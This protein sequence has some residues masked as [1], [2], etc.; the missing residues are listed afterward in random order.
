[1]A[2][3][4]FHVSH[5]LNR[6]PMHLTVLHVLSLAIVVL[7]LST[8]PTEAADFH[9]AVDGSD[10]NP[11]TA[12]KPFATLEKARDA[13]RSWRKSNPADAA[14]TVS[15][16]GGHYEIPKPLLLTDEDSGTEQAPVRWRNDKNQKVVLSGGRT[17]R[18]FKPVTDDRVLSRLPKD[19]HPHV[20]Q[21]DLSDSN[22]SDLGDVAGAG[23]RIEL[24]F[25]GNP[26]TLARWPNEGFTTVVDVNG[27]QP[28]QV[29]GIKGDAVGRFIYQGEQ[30]TR[31]TREPDVWVFG[32]WFWDWSDGVQPV[33][34]ID[35]ATKTI[36]LAPPHHSYGFRKGQRF[37][38]F[39]ILAE[40]DQP[41]EWYLDRE[42]RML[43]FWPPTNMPDLSVTLSTTPNLLSIKNASW[44]TWQG[45]QFEACRA[46]AIEIEQG[47]GVRIAGCVVR[48]TGT[49]GITIHQGTRHGVIGCDIDQ[50]GE[51]G[52]SLVGGDRKTLTPAG[53]VAE[54]NHIHH[55]ARLIRTYRP[56]IG[57]TGVGHRLS[58]NLIHDA[59]HT[60]ILLHGND[61]L[62][63]FN[64]IHHVCEETGDV[65]A[66][67]LGRDWTE[68][69]NTVKHN[70]FH[71]IKGPGLHGA[72]S[73]Y[74]DD[75]ASGTTI[76]GNLFHKAS[77]A[78]FIG[79]GRDNIVENNI[80]VECEPSVHLDARGTNWMHETVAPNGTMD[81]RL[82]D[83]PFQEPP[84]STRYPELVNIR[85]EKPAEPRG[86]RVLRNVS[87]GGRWLDLEKSAA[88]GIAFEDNLID[89]DPGFVDAKALNF[90]LKADS[91]AWALGFR[92]IPLE[93]IGLIQNEDRQSRPRSST[94]P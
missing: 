56:A 50:T 37:Y 31:W 18:N 89:Q 78:A 79:G 57:L 33:K 49:T 5:R 8:F 58:H 19:S 41:G 47:T 70:Y 28:F 10:Q 63:E 88:G 74:L 13:V 51:G 80:F 20:L 15:L 25:D 36:E 12:D 22:L 45:I 1:M 43:Y 81:K 83:V 85:N 34:S 27:G 71:D 53:H 75:A 29:H 42:N 67:Y 6:I 73:V 69:G 62:I 14:I 65:G 59:P 48:N 66:F 54:N 9:V 61:H 2:F 86:N 30:P 40:L 11:G 35:P 24:F 21:A 38:A 32:Y 92:R 17:V 23:K 16:H 60:A 39:N 4:S 3:H 44:I 82:D 84:W 46:T 26:M 52:I 87:M 94:S 76:Y 68:R 90:Q 93:Q 77:R 55:Y 7:G 91:P 64:E 72:M